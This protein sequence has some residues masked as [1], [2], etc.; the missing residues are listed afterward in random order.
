[1]EQIEANPTTAQQVCTPVAAYTAGAY[2]F[3]QVPVQEVVKDIEEAE[4]KMSSV[5]SIPGKLDTSNRNFFQPLTTFNKA[6]M[7]IS[8][9][10][11]GIDDG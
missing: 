9:V 6:V 7:G 8:K 4:K 1:M 3:H 10:G 11:L 5:Q 2:D